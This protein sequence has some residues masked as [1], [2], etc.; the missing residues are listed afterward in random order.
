MLFIFALLTCYVLDQSVM[1]LFI[2]HARKIVPYAKLLFLHL[3]KL[4]KPYF[5]L[6]IMIMWN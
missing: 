3:N 5:K 1:L 4:I 6:Y 2:I